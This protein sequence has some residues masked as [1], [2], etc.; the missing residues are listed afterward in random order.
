MSASDASG[1]ETDD[2]VDVH[3][4][5]SPR[6]RRP[7][8]WEH[9]EP[10][11]VNVNGDLKAVCRYCKAQL[12]T[13]S[14]TSSLRS[15]IA[16]Y[17]PAIEEDVREKFTETMKGRHPAGGQFVFDPKA[18]RER[19]IEYCIH[20]EI[21]F[22][23]WEDPYCQP[24]VHSMQPS[25]DVKGRQTMRNDCFNK[26][27][28]MKQELQAELHNLDSRICITSDMWTSSQ[29]LGYMAVTAHYIDAEFRMKK[30]ILS[31]K[32]V[33]YPHTGYAIEEAIASSLTEWGIRSKLFTLTLDNA[34]SNT[35]A[36]AELIRIYKQELLF[37]GR[38]LHVR[39]CAHILNILVQDGMQIIHSAIEK[40][41]G[42][43]LKTK[44]GIYIDFPT[45]WNSTYKMLDQA[46]NYRSILNNYAKDYL[47]T[48]LSDE[49][50]EKTEAIHAFLKAFE[51]LTS[52]VSAHRTPT[53][54]KFIPSVLSARFALSN[55]AWQSNEVIKKLAA[56]MQVKF[57]KYWD[58][59]EDD[60]PIR[61]T[62]ESRTRKKKQEYDINRALVIATLLD[63][64]RKMTYVEFFYRKVSKSVDQYQTRVDSALNWFKE[65]F[66]VYE[67][68]LRTNGTYQM[69]HS[70]QDSRS[71][72]SPVLGK[73]QIDEE[74]AQ[75][76]S[77]R[78]GSRASRS[79]IDKYLEVDDE[80]DTKDFDILDWWKRHTETF[81]ILSTMA[82]DFLSIPISTVASESAFSCG[83]R[84]LGDSRSSLTPQMLEALVCAKDWLYKEKNVDDKVLPASTIQGMTEVTSEAFLN[85]V[86]CSIPHGG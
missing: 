76:K 6:G 2:S 24:W 16:D 49:E 1:S 47:E 41:L 69:P 27:A 85:D 11:L 56:A 26:Y 75:Y 65:Y 37:D 73:R 81:P 33:K 55:P 44:A 38:D 17:C 21:P 59:D 45:R 3:T 32:E 58:P 42:A 39:C 61:A 8:V 34:S 71:V 52:T 53:A 14:G 51:E 54:H 7:K 40:I 80:E 67:Q 72:G 31:F 30:K 79:E 46:K 10:N 70:S 50:W 78:R 60:Y 35:S 62:T 5:P 74:Y 15:H 86:A 82:R 18:C 63:P 13:R 48:S 23:Q 4:S 28:Q 19:M 12:Q 36:V 68:R 57:E 43:G 20:A 77:S 22:L 25:F 66:A 84:I 83:G 29:N 64:R 9:F